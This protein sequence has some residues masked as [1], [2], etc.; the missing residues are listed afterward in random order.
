MISSSQ[1]PLPDNTQHSQQTDI[2]APDGIRTHDLS[3]RAAIDLSLRLCSHWNRHDT[4]II[5]TNFI[6]KDFK[7]FVEIESLNKWFKANRP[8]LISDEIRFMQFTCKNSP[9]IGHANKLI[10][11][12]YSTKFLGI[13]VDSMLSWKNL[14]E[15]IT[16]IKCGLLCSEIS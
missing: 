11:K 10:S 1:R 4:S 9:Q 12:A 2:H 15:Q 14:V 5:F 7:N 6:L 16:Q 13:Y 8:L 3:R